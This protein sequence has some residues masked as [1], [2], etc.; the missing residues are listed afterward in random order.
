VY[1][2]LFCCNLAIPSVMT[3]LKNVVFY[4]LGQRMSDS[5]QLLNPK[6]F[7]RQTAFKPNIAKFNNEFDFYPPRIL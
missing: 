7:D 1:A 6:P 2:L 4:R 3:K 5:E